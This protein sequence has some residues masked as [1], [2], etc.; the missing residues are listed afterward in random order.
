MPFNEI[1]NCARLLA[2]KR[3]L[4]RAILEKD[5]SPDRRLTTTMI[6]ELEKVIHDMCDDYEDR[7]DECLL[8]AAQKKLRADAEDEGVGH[9]RARR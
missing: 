4:N 3:T 9:G 5:G 8:S 7:T 1:E 6:V 2:I